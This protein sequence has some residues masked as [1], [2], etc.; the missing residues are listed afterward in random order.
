MSGSVRLLLFVTLAA[1]GGAGGWAAQR[2]EA[3][4]A[5]AQEPI[6]ALLSEV[7]QLRIAM[8]EMASTGPRVQLVLGRLQ[9]QEQRINN[10]LH[11]LE[12][13]RQ[14]IE[15]IQN[16]NDEQQRM[17]KSFETEAAGV[18]EPRQRRDFEEQARVIKSRLNG[19]VA[20]LQQR[21]AEESALSA[22]IGS[23]QAR[24]NDFNGRLEELERALG[25]KQK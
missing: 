3:Q 15:L 14:E 16:E 1:A 4:P 8:E 9:L 23:E 18:V 20:R 11:R 21:Q 22:D 12:T 10:M 5:P 6:P 17:L 2:A 13:V 19:T 25:K 24:W 7:R